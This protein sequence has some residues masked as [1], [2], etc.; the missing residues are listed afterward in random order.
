M[1]WCVCCRVKWVGSYPLQAGCTGFC[2]CRQPNQ[3]VK[4][5]ERLAMLS[6]GKNIQGKGTVC[7]GRNRNQWKYLRLGGRDQFDGCSG[8]GRMCSDHDVLG[9]WWWVDQRKKSLT[10]LRSEK[11]KREGWW[12]KFRDLGFRTFIFSEKVKQ[13]LAPERR[14]MEW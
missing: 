2:D 6:Q 11:W 10:P 3:D 7:E 5:E 8:A 14:V 12:G 4:N 13:T 9:H 1:G